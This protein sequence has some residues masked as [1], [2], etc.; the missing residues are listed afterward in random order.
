MF[1]IGLDVHQSRSSV[2]ILESQGNPLRRQEIPGGWDKLLEFLQHL[3]RPW[4]ICFEASTGYGALYD[5]LSPLAARI[6]VANPNRLRLIYQSKRKSDRI[7]AAK[8]AM[9]LHLGQVPQV[10]VPSQEVRSWRGLIEHRRKL[11]DKRVSVKNQLRALLRSFGIKAPRTR[12]L[13]TLAGKQWLQELTWPTAMEPLRLNCLLDQIDS[14]QNQIHQAN[15]ALDVISGKYPGVAL[16]QSIPG[17][18]PRTAEAFVAYIDD[19]NRFKSSTIGAYLGLVPGEDSSGQV[20]RLGHIT[21][22]GPGTVRKL[23]A[24]AAWRGRQDS[25]TIR[26]VYDRLLRND[27]HRRKIALVGLTHWLSR[28]MLAML[29]SREPFRESAAAI[30]KKTQTPE[31]AGV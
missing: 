1:T 31:T 13:W 30:D 10:H 21:H 24:E 12:Q 16:L 7:D 19:P 2:C 3:E 20:R 26:C 14:L 23:L 25:P 8:L 18:G 15:S 5:R 9:L 6:V 4:Q 27:K 29:Q 17:T 28:V 22:E 11:V